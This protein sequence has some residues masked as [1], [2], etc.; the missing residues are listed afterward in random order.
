[1]EQKIAMTRSIG[2]DLA[3]LMNGLRM[4][5]GMPDRFAE[6]PEGSTSVGSK[7]LQCR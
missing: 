5:G 4:G 6:S 2:W 3:L 7:K 1:M